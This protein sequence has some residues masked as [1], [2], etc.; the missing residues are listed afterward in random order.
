MST[1]LNCDHP[2]APLALLAEPALE[3][4]MHPRGV[5]L[6]Q[7]A[8]PTCELH[9]H[10]RAKLLPAL[11][12]RCDFDAQ[13]LVDLL[14]AKGNL[15]WDGREQAVTNVPFERPAHD[16]WGVGKVMLIHCDDCM[17]KVYH[18]PWWTS[19]PAW[20]KAIE[21][22]FE[23]LGVPAHRVV[24][25]LLAKL[26]PRTVIPVRTSSVHFTRPSSPRVGCA[27][28]ARVQLLG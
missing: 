15:A 18:M 20:K 28:F 13:P 14:A 24:R 23:A 22:L 26:P 8:R 17:K 25:C 19:D 10:A 11:V 2:D 21:P 27:T 1:L 3:P 5:P 4:E 12:K 7:L 9:P 16:R 6:N